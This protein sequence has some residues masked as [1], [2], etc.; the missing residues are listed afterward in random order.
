MLSNTARVLLL[1]TLAFACN[2]DT[3]SPATE[4]GE[5][6]KCVNEYFTIA[7]SPEDGSTEWPWQQNRPQK[8]AAAVTPTTNPPTALTPPYEIKV[9][10]PIAGEDEKTAPVPDVAPLD[11]EGKHWALG[12]LELSAGYRWKVVID[13]SDKGGQTDMCELVFDL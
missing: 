5:E 1:G 7:V 4:V 3:D 11:A 12:P 9:N 10:A 8:L 2:P 6:I 13:I